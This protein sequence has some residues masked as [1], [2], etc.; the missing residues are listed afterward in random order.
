[1]SQFYIMKAHHLTTSGRKL[2]LRK[3]F[4]DEPDATVIMATRHYGYNKRVPV[5]II[6]CRSDYKVNPGKQSTYTIDTG[7]GYKCRDCVLDIEHIFQVENGRIIEAD[8]VARNDGVIPQT[9]ARY[10]YVMK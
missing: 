9:D 3:I 1:M 7:M 5:F 6:G 2:N 8:G 4:R 10:T